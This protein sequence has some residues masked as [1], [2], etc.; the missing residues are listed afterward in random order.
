MRDVMTQSECPSRFVEGSPKARHVPPFML[1]P[2]SAQHH[3][4]GWKAR[5]HNA[6]TKVWT[7]AQTMDRNTLLGGNPLGVLIRLVLISLVVGIILSAIG[8][9][10]QNLFYHLD[11]LARRLYDLGFGVFENVLGYI[12]LGALVVVPIW[13]VA[14]FFGVLT[15]KKSQGDRDT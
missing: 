12:V 2:G 14:R 13:L 5:A 8:I 15:S 4:G 11:V 10:P 9:T 7:R 1:K 6:S 3:M